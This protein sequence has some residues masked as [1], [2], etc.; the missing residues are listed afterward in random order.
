MSSKGSHEARQRGRELALGVL[1]HLESYPEQE[2]SEAWR[3]VL[4]DPPVGDDVGEDVFASLAGDTEARAFASDLVE[5]AEKHR[6][7]IDASITD[8]SA[9]WRLER[10]DRV[11]RNVLRLAAT[12]FMTG[13]DV[14][15]NVV[16]AEAVRLASRYGSERSS[17]F[18]NGVVE[19][20]AS[21]LRPADEGGP[22]REPTA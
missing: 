18:V 3:V 11:D 12:E 13:D 1:C 8:A 14:P 6:A 15:R 10:M 16:V 4:D 17:K 7:E 21:R 22:A 5:R 19:T 20:L 9:R 2:R